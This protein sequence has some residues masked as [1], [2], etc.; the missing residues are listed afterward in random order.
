MIRRS[1]YSVRTDGDYVVVESGFGVVCVGRWLFTAEWYACAVHGFGVERLKQA[2]IR[3]VVDGVK[4]SDVVY[5]SDLKLM[6]VFGIE[7]EEDFYDYLVRVAAV[8]LI[9]WLPRY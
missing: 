1:G 2:L 4:E 6:K 3:F 9:P 7:K 5:M 8:V